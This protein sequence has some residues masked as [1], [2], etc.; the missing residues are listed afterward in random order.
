[1]HLVSGSDDSRSYAPPLPL[2]ITVNGGDSGVQHTSGFLLSPYP[3]EPSHEAGRTPP[4]AP[5]I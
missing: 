1:M 4:G 5:G 3:T 2:N